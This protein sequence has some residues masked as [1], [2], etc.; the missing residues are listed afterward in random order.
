MAQTILVAEDN[1][2][3][4]A[5]IRLYLENAGYRVKTADT[6]PEALAMARQ[7]A[8]DLVILDIMLPQL[9][10]LDVCRLLRAESEVPI[11]M[12]TA[13]TL[14]EDRILGFDLGAD[15]YVSK[16]FSPRELV[17]RVRAILRRSTTNG[18]RTQTPRRYGSLAIDVTRHMVSVD[19]R[20]VLLTA[21]EFKL[22]EVV[23]R[24]PGQVFSRE[25]LVAAVFGS[26]YQGLNRTIDAH[27]MNLRKK[28]EPDPQHPGFILTV[29]GVGY[30]FSDD[31]S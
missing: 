30:K 4:S 10:G 21:T 13:R 6:G 29:F 11:L 26:E 18:V 15:D 28:I 12:L 1:L 2:K 24:T 9:S 22:L 16:P 20:P 27:V 25:V 23:S 7:S 14:E 19:G 17:K 3:T 31:V 8:P 5:S